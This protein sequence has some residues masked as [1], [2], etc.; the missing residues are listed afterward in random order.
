MLLI[1]EY[2]L[3]K[4]ISLLAR[5]YHEK[6]IMLVKLEDFHIRAHQP[7]GGWRGPTVV[8]HSGRVPEAC[9]QA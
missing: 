5:D 1:V 7:E 6:W 2:L 8:S 3:D 9:P 4:L